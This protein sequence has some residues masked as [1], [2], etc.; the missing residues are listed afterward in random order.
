MKN[1]IHGS[2][3]K[4]SGSEKLTCTEAN[5]DLMTDASTLFS[6]CRLIMTSVLGIAVL[7]LALSELT[8]AFVPIGGG[9]S[10][11]I[12]ITGTALLQKVTETCQAVAEAAGHEFK[13]TVG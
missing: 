4:F 1:L 5:S 9:T 7:A 12:S 13:P 10:T 11:H 2:G 8:V 3:F 6:P